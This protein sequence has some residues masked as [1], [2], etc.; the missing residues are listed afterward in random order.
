LHQSTNEICYNCSNELRILFLIF[1][2]FILFNERIQQHQLFLQAQYDNFLTIK[3]TRY[4]HAF[5]SH[6]IN[7]IITLFYLIFN[8]QK[9]FYKSCVPSSF[10]YSDTTDTLTSLHLTR[11]CI[12]STPWPAFLRFLLQSQWKKPTPFRSVHSAIALIFSTAYNIIQGDFESCADI[13]IT[14]YWLHVELG[15]ND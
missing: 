13:L 8:L 1:N 2:L 4:Y 15:K 3:A 10:S 7:I 12:F 9:L 6:S 14:S 11:F 5:I